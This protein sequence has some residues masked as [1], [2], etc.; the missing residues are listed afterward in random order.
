VSLGIISSICASMAGSSGR[1]SKVV[2]GSFGS[3]E[4]PKDNKVMEVIKKRIDVFVG[5][6]SIDTQL[7]W[8]VNRQ[9]FSQRCT[10]P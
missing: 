6:C 1:G 10:G 7:C 5:T 9:G 4:H 2:Q 3:D 8:H